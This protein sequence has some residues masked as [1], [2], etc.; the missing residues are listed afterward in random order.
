MSCE[1]FSVEKHSGESCF[2]HRK[3]SSIGCVYDRLVRA[4]P[5]LLS[6]SWPSG[7]EGGIAHRLDVATSGQLIV[8]RTVSSLRHV[9]ALFEQKQLQKQ[10]WF[11][12]AS[13]PGFE[14]QVVSLS[15]GHHPKSRK[16]MVVR[17][18]EHSRL[19]GKWYPAETHFQRLG[20]E[21]G[22]TL[23]Q[24]TMRSGVM[25]QIRVHAKAAGIPLLGDVLYGGGKN[26]LELPAQ[27]ALHHRG[28]HAIK[29][30]LLDESAIRP[31]PLPPSW[32]SWAHSLV[33]RY[34]TGGG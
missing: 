1:I 30:D 13:E 4:H 2:P 21:L 23:W 7:F 33:M 15:I 31:A 24:A 14:K 16:K 29:P 32:P 6:I 10:Y 22:C 3:D 9:R 20:K 34:S 5:E 27:F 17:Q 19:R 18:H 26:D 11:L 28:L 8:C 25:H 12:S